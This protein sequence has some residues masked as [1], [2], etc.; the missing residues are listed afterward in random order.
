MSLSDPKDFMSEHKKFLIPVFLMIFLLACTGSYVKPEQVKGIYHRIKKGETLYGISRAYH[1][2]LQ[3]IAELNDITNPAAIRAGDAIFIPGAD[4]VAEPIHESSDV[5]EHRKPAEKPSRPPAQAQSAAPTQAQP[6]PPPYAAPNNGRKPESARAVAVQPDKENAGKELAAMEKP[7]V[8][9]LAPA[10]HSEVA[11]EQA[12]TDKPAHP[13]DRIE[14]DRKRFIWPVKGEILSRYGIQ[15][16][17]SKNN[18]IRIAGS[19]N[20]PVLAA[21]AGEVTYSGTLKYYGDTIIL[22]HDDHFSTVYTSLKNRSVKVGDRVK[23]GDK[24][25]LL[26]K[27]DTGRAFL[28]FEIR[29]VNKPRNP[30]FFLP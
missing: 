8:A 4:K 28:T 5:R 7:P 12:K 26:G 19:E 10:P 18:G 11:K 22:R 15:P 27:N 30:L 24:I 29:Q 2:D 21:A 25:A 1:A 6:A 16:N 17:G 20:T 9:K 14:F 23:R 13:D 3:E